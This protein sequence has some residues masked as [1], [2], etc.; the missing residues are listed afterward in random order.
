MEK[1]TLKK[2]IR[3]VRDLEIKKSV[4]DSQFEFYNKKKRRIE[5][6]ERRMMTASSNFWDEIS[7]EYYQNMIINLIN[8]HYCY[9]W[10]AETDSLVMLNR[11]T[12]DKIEFKI[13]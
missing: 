4:N 8:N 2:I 12:G 6:K 13:L 9:L 11:H 10:Q 1:T 7:G 5:H 3:A